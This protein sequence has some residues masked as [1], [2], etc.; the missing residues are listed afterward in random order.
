MAVEVTVIKSTAVDPTLLQQVAGTMPEWFQQGGMVMWLLLLTSFVVTII[1]LER[2]SAWV[3]YLL[4]KEHFLINDCFAALNKNEKEQALLCCQNLDTPA[5]NMLKH[6]INSL[7][8]SPKE[9]MQSYAK[10]QVNVM[11]QGQPL[12][13]SA[14][15]IALILGLLGTILGLVDS[16]N[17]LSFQQETSLAAISGAVAHALIASASGLCVALFAFIPYKTFQTQSNKLNDHLQKIS[18]DFDYICQ[19][20]SL[21]TNQISEIMALQEKRLSEAISTTE[22]VAEQSEMPYHYEFKEG[23]DE[24]NVSLHEEMQDL[25]KTSQSSLID[26]YKEELSASPR[27]RKKGVNGPSSLFEMYKSAVNEDQE[28]YGVNEVELQEQQETAHLKKVENE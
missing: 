13:R 25:Q 12:L 15:I 14:V 20:K 16:L 24:V 1:T 4:K 23:S 10:H 27:K 26:M 18:G 8:F 17:S 9:R 21:V 7:P 22:T 6:G 5:L 3:T 28:L 11:A 19:Q 2:A